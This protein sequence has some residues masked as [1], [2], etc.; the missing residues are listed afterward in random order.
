MWHKQFGFII[1]N[2]LVKR[3][4]L[5]YFSSTVRLKLN[6][7][8]GWLAFSTFIKQWRVVYSNCIQQSEKWRHCAENKLDKDKRAETHM[9]FNESEVL[10]SGANQAFCWLHLYWHYKAKNVSPTWASVLLLCGPKNCQYLIFA[11]ILYSCTHSFLTWRY[12][13]GLFNSIYSQ[14]STWIWTIQDTHAIQQQHEIWDVYT[15]S[16]PIY[17][18]INYIHSMYVYYII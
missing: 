13:G 2:I 3:G 8:Q 14:T 11:F 1:I 7:P 18:N 6:P 16:H 15:V 4:G 5:L 12:S 10:Q 17:P 9:E